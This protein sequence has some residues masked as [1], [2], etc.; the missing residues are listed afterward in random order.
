MN[1]GTLLGDGKLNP[2]MYFVQTPAFQRQQAQVILKL[3]DHNWGVD[4][5]KNVGSDK[6]DNTVVISLEMMYRCSEFTK[7]PR[8]KLDLAIE[9]GIN[10]Q[11]MDDKEYKDYD[12]IMEFEISNQRIQFDH[13]PRKNTK[14]KSTAGDVKG[15]TENQIFFNLYNVR[16]VIRIRFYER[17]K[18]GVLS[19]L[20]TETRDLT[21]LVLVDSDFET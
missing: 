16:D 7:N 12:P 21:S 4:I 19:L 11:I 15:W 6:K 3:Q 5:E 10:M 20:G 18:D 2:Q 14:A 1:P 8:G 17:R 13:T 9:Q